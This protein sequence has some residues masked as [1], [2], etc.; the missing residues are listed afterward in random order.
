V[1]A[2]KR[3]IGVIK[4][5]MQMTNSIEESRMIHTHNNTKDN[6]LNFSVPDKM[7]KQLSFK[8]IA[9]DK[10]KLVISTN[11]L[12]LF[13]FEAND[14]TIERSLGDNQGIV[15]ERARDLFD[16]V[17][18]KKVYSRIYKHR[19][20][21]PI[22]E[23]LDIGSQKL[24]STSFPASCERVHI[25]FTQ[26]KIYVRPLTSIQEKAIAN[27]KNATDQL[28]VFAACSS[29][30]DLQSLKEN[31][32]RVH[33]L[34]EWRPQEARDKKDLTETGALVALANTENIKSVF[35][36]DISSIDTAQLAKA[37]A[38]SP[39]TLFHMSL[40]CDDYS[41]VKAAKLKESSLKDL[42]SS[43]DMG[44]DCLRLIEAMAPPTVLLENVAG[45][46][47]SDM[48]KVISLRMRRWG[49]T[50]HE[51]VGDA[52]DYGGMTSRKRAYTFF[53][54]L[55]HKFEWE[56][57]TTRSVTPIW[58]TIKNFLPEC[59]DVTHS[60][61][62]QDGLVCGRLRTITKISAHSP[63]LLKSQLRMAK[64]SVVIMDE[65]R[66]YWPTE[67]LMKFLMGIGE[68]FDLS[69]CSSTIASE[70]IGQSVDMPLHDA[71]VRSIRNHIED[72]YVSSGA[73]RAA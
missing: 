17:K 30:V 37:A 67:K 52:S 7:T 62:L 72:F 48:Y 3:T 23:L 46:L 36:E 41:P 39:Y 2:H 20:N 40:Q 14:P 53:T 56:Q 60:K 34:I 19:K 9:D 25:T 4:R 22:E 33:S 10:R 55:P 66:L 64:D 12:P 1:Y 26:D 73:L 47:K 5:G 71:M 16:Q 44:Y 31:E 35:N 8:K 21:N 57:P 43:I 59:R 18:T 68:D 32:F 69:C 45:W 58:E 11:W 27:A 6:V 65:D 15:I 42:S 49:Y 13:G 70:V 28:S 29:G 24:L 54:A 38:E 61:S 50:E 63:T 51:L